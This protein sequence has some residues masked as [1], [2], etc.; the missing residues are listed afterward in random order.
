MIFALLQEVFITQPPI[1]VQPVT[2]VDV[3]VLVIFFVSLPAL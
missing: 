1:L 2:T 3:L